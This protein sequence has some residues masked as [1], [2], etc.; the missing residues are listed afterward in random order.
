[1]Q[2]PATLAEALASL[3]ERLLAART[4]AGHWR[5]ELS[6]SALATAT[7][8]GALAAIDAVGHQQLIRQ[9]LDWL[10][11]NANAD[12]GWGDS[13]VSESNL[14]A[15]LLVWSAFAMAAGEGEFTGP[16]G[17]A[18][19]WLSVR[20]G[21]TQPEAIAAA[22]LDVYG[23]DR[24]FSVPILTMCALAGRLG[25][26]VE[27]WRYVPALPFEL[28]VVPQ[29]WLKALR[30]PVVS[31]ALPALVAMGLVRNRAAPP[32]NPITRLVRRL[33]RGRSMK[34]VTRIQPADG[35][36]LEAAPL[37]SFVAMSLARA[38]LADHPVVSRCVDFL[39]ASVRPDG[40]WPI[41]TDLATWVTTL[42]VNALADGA[43]AGDERTRIRQWLLGQQHLAGHP[44]TAASPGGWAWT[45]L[46]GGVPDGDDTAG[47]LL[48]LRRLGEIDQPT[49][50]AGRAGA[51][52]L[53]DLQNRDGGTPTFCR[54]WGRLPFDRSSPD[55]TAHAV[56]ALDAWRDDLEAASR[57]RCRRA[58]GRAL[59]YLARAQSADGAW[60]PLW[61]GNERTPGQTN[62]TYGTA[63]VVS[64]LTRLD[65]GE[66]AELISQGVGWLAPA[67]NDDGGWGGSAG[68]PSSIEETGVAVDALA[69]ALAGGRLADEAGELRR[70]VNAGVDWLI[71]HAAG[72]SPLPAAPIGLYFERLWY[73]ERLYPLIFAA[74]ALRATSGLQ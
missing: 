43:L 5:G 32:T 7:A 16:V 53:M 23:D 42:S 51:N 64:A 15:T 73:S 27:A 21:S 11:R 46:S 3:T 33:A 58:I 38:G 25:E 48:A 41:D 60:T 66:P 49:L 39:T 67:Q 17:G 72:A 24:T 40:S 71:E 52:W 69:G 14:S 45:D 8:V 63:R 1:M 20:L 50:A 37:T 68:A 9:G 22:V 61:F 12:G 36:F 47:A 74:A 4:P 56:A 19:E 54:G 30:L 28:A 29:R 62:P 35:G 31:Y 34:V 18:E 57:R 6:S 55:I 2:S 10:A 70:A 13:T 26:G 44:Y 65:G 59:A